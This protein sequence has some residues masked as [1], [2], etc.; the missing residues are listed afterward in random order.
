MR[1]NNL[2]D[3]K[4]QEFALLCCRCQHRVDFF[5]KGSRPRHEC[6]NVR[7]NKFTCYMFKPI[8]PLA[9][10]RLKSEPKFRPRFSM[11]LISARE[12]GTVLDEKEFKLYGAKT[13]RGVILYWVPIIYKVV[14]NRNIKKGNK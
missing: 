9:L 12:T 10:N 8:L 1:K 4:V 5:E 7:R 3:G 13:K 14:K 2:T 6:G 11:P